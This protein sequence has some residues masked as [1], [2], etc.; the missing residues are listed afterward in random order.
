MKCRAFCYVMG[1]G[2]GGDRSPSCFLAFLRTDSPRAWKQPHNAVDATV[3]APSRSRSPQKSL[4]P[5]EL[6]VPLANPPSQ[7]APRL[8]RSPRSHGPSSTPA[9]AGHAEAPGM[10][11][12]RLTTSSRSTRPPVTHSPPGTTSGSRHPVTQPHLGRGRLPSHTSH[13]ASAYHRQALGLPA[14][15]PERH[16]THLNSAHTRLLLP[17][18]ET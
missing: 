15:L 18:E 9:T 14:A 3:G 8:G 12:H 1:G 5:P 13:P 17:K 4:L 10:L 2:G 6:Q 7:D 16:P 11:A